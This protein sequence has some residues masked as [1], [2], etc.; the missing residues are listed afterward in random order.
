MLAHYSCCS[1]V[2]E[3]I[4]IFVIFLVK[5]LFKKF[6]RCKVLPLKY[7][8]SASKCYFLVPGRVENSRQNNRIWLF[9]LCCSKCLA[10]FFQ[11]KAG[12]FSI[13]IDNKK[14]L[15]HAQHTHLSQVKHG[16]GNIVW[17]LVLAPWAQFLHLP[18]SEIHK[19]VQSRCLPNIFNTTD[20]HYTV[21]M[22]G[23]LK[24]FK[25]HTRNRLTNKIFRGVEK[26]NTCVN[27]LI[28]NY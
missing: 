18:V 21:A 14:I 11:I 12:R 28:K 20:I 6:Y 16:G 25:I 23:Q 5:L 4:M 1:D 19:T 8:S 2:I 10:P 9:Q 22:D 24:C 7:S 17:P 26:E 15:A 3:F 13:K 27:I